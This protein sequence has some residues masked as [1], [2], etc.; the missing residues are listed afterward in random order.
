MHWIAVTRASDVP[1]GA[2]FRYRLH[3]SSGPPHTYDATY[4]AA[5]YRR[6]D[7]ILYGRNEHYGWVSAVSE[8]SVPLLAALEY[9][10]PTEPV[11]TVRRFKRIQL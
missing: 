4:T 3:N 2:M 8:P 1:N 10:I 11:P 6:E 7:G 5:E 9:A